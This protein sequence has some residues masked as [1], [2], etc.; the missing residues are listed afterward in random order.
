V[1]ADDYDPDRPPANP[2]PG[3][4]QL[5]A[6]S[7]DEIAR[8]LEAFTAVVLHLEPDDVLII[9]PPA[10]Y[11]IIEVTQLAEVMGRTMPP[12]VRLG[13]IDPRVNLD[14]WRAG[15]PPPLLEVAQPGQV[16]EVMQTT[17]L[18]DR[19]RRR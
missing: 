19:P 18:R 12:G 3:Q 9:R 8:V 4:L 5:T 1:P 13:I 15:T 6:P 14:V 10:G 7:A 11:S 16:A 2:T 17:D